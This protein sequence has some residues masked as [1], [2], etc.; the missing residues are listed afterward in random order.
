MNQVYAKRLD[1]NES[2]AVTCVK[3]SGTVSQLVDAASGMHPRYAPYYVRRVRISAQDPL[4]AMLKEQ[5]FPYH[6]EV[7]QDETTASTFV[8]EFPVCAP[9]GCITR[10][11]L[12]AIDQLEYWRMVKENYTEHNPSVTVS[13]AEEEWIEIANWLYNHWDI[14]GGLSFLPRTDAVYQLAPFEEIT[15]EEYQKRIMEL[16]Q[17]D[18]SHIVVY[19]KEDA[20]L[21]AKE[22]ACA[23][24]GCEID[25]EEGS[26]ARGHLGPYS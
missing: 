18:F 22:P 10:T 13:V 20:T 26:P 2:A 7:G 14:V 4:F 17:T 23:G 15:A 8:L 19:E 25:P 1:L 9:K 16:P 11:D 5:K 6:P 21:G 24:G 3:P 12:N